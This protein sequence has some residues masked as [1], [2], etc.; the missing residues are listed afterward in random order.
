MHKFKFQLV[1]FKNNCGQDLE[2]FLSRWKS[3]IIDIKAMPLHMNI[4]L[5]IKSRV[6]KDWHNRFKWIYA[7]LC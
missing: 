7:T 5:S 3:W 2:T 1:S 4:H 6:V